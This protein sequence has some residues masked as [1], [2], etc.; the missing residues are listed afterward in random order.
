MRCRVVLALLQQQRRRHLAVVV[1]VSLMRV[2]QVHPHEVVR[3]VSVLHWLMATPTAMHMAV[4]VPWSARAGKQARGEPQEHSSRTEAAL[5]TAP[6]ALTATAVGVGSAR[7]RVRI[8]NIF[9]A[10][11]ELKERRH[12]VLQQPRRMSG[13]RRAGNRQSED[14]LV[15]RYGML[16]QRRSG[17]RAL[18]Q[19]TAMRRTWQRGAM[20][21]TPV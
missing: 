8:A 15:E 4:V 20:T 13:A 12:A 9:R 16:R 18:S 14:E 10:Q 1:A 19:C 17:A 6:R 7:H 5:T 3:V 2:V 11:S 21:L